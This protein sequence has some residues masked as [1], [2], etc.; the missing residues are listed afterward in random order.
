M[1]ERGCRLSTGQKQFVSL[2]R[3]VLADPQLLILDEATSSLDTETERRVQEGVD[4][5]LKGRTSI[6]IA[7]RLSTI[8]SA[9]RILVIDEGEIVES[10]SHEEL[11]AKRGAYHKLY[12]QQFSEEGQDRVIELERS[13]R[14]EASD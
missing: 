9:D 8:R 4:T 5:L 7:H 12:T 11:L 10:G 6:I 1:G 13:R 14:G 3:A 2:A